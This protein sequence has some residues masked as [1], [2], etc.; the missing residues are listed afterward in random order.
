[1]VHDVGQWVGASVPSR[2]L[3]SFKVGASTPDS[4]K[5]GKVITQQ[6]QS[7]VVQRQRI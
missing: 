5:L 7:H 2:G 1:M 3:V 4:S 6:Q